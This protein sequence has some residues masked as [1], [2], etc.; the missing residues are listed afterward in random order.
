MFCCGG[1]FGGSG[2]SGGCGGGGGSGDGGGG[3][4]G[5]RGDDCDYNAKENG[6]NIETKC[7]LV[8]FG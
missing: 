2:S 6:L 3:G 5:G 8:V 7:L 1:D 4:V